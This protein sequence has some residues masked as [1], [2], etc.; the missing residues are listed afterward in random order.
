MVDR[1]CR[2]A[3]Q[4]LFASVGLPGIAD[5]LMACRQIGALGGGRVALCSTDR[6]RLSTH[7]RPTR[8]IHRRTSRGAGVDSTEGMAHHFHPLRRGCLLLLLPWKRGTSAQLLSDCAEA[9]IPFTC[10]ERGFYW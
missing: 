4:V 3:A 2:S 10:M 6:S 5:R 7:I 9:V 8:R 1:R